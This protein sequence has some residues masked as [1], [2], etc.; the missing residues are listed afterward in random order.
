MGRLW[1]L[2]VEVSIPYQN[3]PF[4]NLHSNR[5]PWFWP[6]S[7]N[8]LATPSLKLRLPWPKKLYFL[9]PHWKGYL[10]CEFHFHRK[11]FKFWLF[12]THFLWSNTKENNSYKQWNNKKL[13]NFFYCW[14]LVGIWHTITVQS[15]IVLAS[16]VLE[17][18]G[19][20][21]DPLEH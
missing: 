10:P 7:L 19:G 11:H 8:F 21:N 4:P 15:L 2:G 12:L 14:F 5:F 13:E 20:Q 6:F 3:R 17:L 16:L 18:V 1:Y 9:N